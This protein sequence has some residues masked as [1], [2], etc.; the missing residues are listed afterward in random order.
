MKSIHTATLRQGGLSPHDALQ[1]YNGLDCALTVEIF[2]EVSGPNMSEVS[3]SARLVYDFE[4]GMQAP[5][6]DMMMRGWKVDLFKRDLAVATLERQRRIVQE[7]L[8]EFV[9]V[10]WENGTS[11]LDPRKKT[12]GLNPASP[13]QMKEFLYERLNLPEQYSYAKGERRLTTNREALEKLD[14][15]FHARPFVRCVL[16]LRDLSK[17]ISVLHTEVSSDGRMH[18]SYNVTGTETGRWSSSRSAFDEGTNLQNI[19]E[20]LRSIFVADPGKKLAYIDKSQA[21]SRALGFIIWD[22]FG[23]PAYLDACES[24]DLH[25]M[26]CKLIWKDLPW[27]GDPEADKEIAEQKFYL[28]YS[29]RDMAKRGGHGTNYYGTPRTMARHLKVR[30]KLIED[31]QAGYFSAFPGIQEYHRWVARKIG[32]HPH[33]LETPL[34]MGRHFFGRPNDDTTLREGI[35]FLPQSMVGQLLNLALWRIWKYAP[36][37]ECL[38]QIH[39]AV[40]IQYDEN[41]EDEI[42][43]KIVS[44]MPTP[45]VS[46]GRTMVIPSDVMV[47]WNWAK[48][49]DKPKGK[50]GKPKPLNLDGLKKWAGHDDRTRQIDPDASGLDRVVSSIY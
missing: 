8:D 45:L 30:V 39:D 10:L 17:K 11:P 47:G 43:P 31:F 4:R 49:N 33:Y 37:V 24:G 21:E 36:E 3:P 26:V 22:L 6:L 28:H 7:I 29:Y 13:K 14:D 40:V 27:T 2:E 16:K 25:T 32:V 50:D 19:T 1:I 35:A 34:G 5:A 42:L 23:D 38:G 41:R 46:R 12:P 15:Y 48:F 9:C 44:L 20:E 18:T